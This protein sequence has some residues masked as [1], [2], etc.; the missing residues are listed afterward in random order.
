MSTTESATGTGAHTI[1]TSAGNTTTVNAIELLKADHRQVEEWFDQFDATEDASRRQQL[2]A[3]IC[4]ALE[5][6]MRL[7][8]EIFYPA[9]LD[10]TGNQSLHHQSIVEHQGARE[11]IG[12][13]R[14]SAGPSADDYLE[15]RVKV[16]AEM[17]HHHVSEEESPGGT[18][19]SAERA[20]VDL[21]AL[22]TRIEQRKLELMDDTDT[23]RGYD[24]AVGRADDGGEVDREFEGN[25]RL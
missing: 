5:V 22:G 7:E 25:D 17:I 19:D 21:D 8:E 16:L 11:L 3:D 6:H 20:G 14:L 18:F 15:A 23:A 12:R 24:E 13:I 9:F 4:K 1:I 2:A 10:A